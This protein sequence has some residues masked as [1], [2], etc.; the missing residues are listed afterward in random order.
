MR[1]Y[2]EIGIYRPKTPMNLGTLWRTASQLGAVGIFVIGQR[3]PEKQSSD[4]LNTWKH[5]PLRKYGS[6]EEF[7]AARPFDCQLVGVEM[8]GSPLAAFKHPERAIYL[9]GAEDN[10]L[11]KDAQKL[12]QSIVELPSLRTAS[13]NVAVAGALVMYDRLTKSAA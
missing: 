2:F 7:Q 5:I 4:T 1:G 6:L 8:G 3:W 13:F 12:C 9:L 11:P 10:G